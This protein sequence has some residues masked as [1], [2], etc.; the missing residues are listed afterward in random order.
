MS[1]ILKILFLASLL[2]SG[3]CSPSTAR[4]FASL[5]QK[6][7]P[8]PTPEKIK[9]IKNDSKVIHILV[10]L[11]DNENQGIVPVPKHLGNGEDPKRNLYW[12][13]A[14]GVKTFFSKSKSW[15]KLSEIKNPKENILERIIFKHRQK[16]VYLIADAYQGSK[17]KSTINDF[18]AA[19]SG[20]LLENI[21]ADD[22]ELQIFGSADVI[23]FVGHN[24][25][26]D[27]DLD[28]KI[29]K[30]D[31]DKREAIILACLSKK[32]FASHLKQTSA[33]PLL[34]TTNL[35]APEAYILHGAFEGWINGETD[36]QIR[37]RAAGAYSKY[38][39]ISLRAA[40]GLLVTGW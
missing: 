23:S 28:E 38:Q 24:G 21:E 34:W 2:L 13:A 26:M 32:Y 40:K 39:K 19:T 9:K 5:A 29:V 25:L 20:E 4:D 6:P 22:K 30:K 27:F 15:Q 12:G 10:A 16:N 3:S 14:Y 11:C 8:A 35:M 36:E 1:N 7:S 17:I 33:R 37:N 31:D 18:I